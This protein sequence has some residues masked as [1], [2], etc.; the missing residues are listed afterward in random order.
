MNYKRTKKIEIKKNNKQE[1]NEQVIQ[2]LQG[3]YHKLIRC[4]S[5]NINRLSNNNMVD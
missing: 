2:M 1:K 4:Y 5:L 3:Y